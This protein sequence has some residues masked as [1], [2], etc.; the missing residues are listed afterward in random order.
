MDGWMNLEAVEGD[1]GV[2][3]Y[4]LQL[5]VAVVGSVMDGVGLYVA[6]CHVLRTGP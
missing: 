5:L 1:G 6:G 4:F 3:G 2:G